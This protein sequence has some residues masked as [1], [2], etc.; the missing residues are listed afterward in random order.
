MDILLIDDVQ[1]IAGKYSIQEE[2]FHTF[3]AIYQVKKQIVITSDKPPEEINKLEMRLRSR[4][5]SGLTIDIGNPDFELRTAII[6]IKA[7]QKGCDLTIESAKL[8]SANIENTRKMEGVLTRVISES[9][10][11]SLPIDNELIKNVLGKTLKKI[12]PSQKATPDEI[13]KAVAEFY[14]L[15]IS[16]L[17]GSKRDKIYSFPRQILYYL[18][19]VESGINLVAIGEFLGGR[20]ATGRAVMHSS[21]KQIVCCAR[22]VGTNN[23]STLHLNAS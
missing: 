7:K 20:E 12:P 10:T 18:L 9:E 6:L 14:Q 19:R 5:E 23:V 8:L 2:F 21:K 16:Q 11:K 17:K 3:N 22:L 1:F 4:F 13:L 15:K